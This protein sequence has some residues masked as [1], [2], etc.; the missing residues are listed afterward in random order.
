MRAGIVYSA[1]TTEPFRKLH[2]FCQDVETFLVPAG[3]NQDNSAGAAQQA[4]WEH[5]KASM[6][7]AS[8]VL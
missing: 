6:P 8:N 4:Q 2:A 3:D 5:G 1:Q 7:E